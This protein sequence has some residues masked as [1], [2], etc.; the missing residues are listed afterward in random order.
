MIRKLQKRFILIT[1]LALTV[2]MVLVVAVVNIANL[3]SVRAELASTLLRCP[4]TCRCPS[5]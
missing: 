1:V 4:Q 3:I 5:G 2:A